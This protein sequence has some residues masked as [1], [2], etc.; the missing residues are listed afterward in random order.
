M[1]VDAGLD[2]WVWTFS[3]RSDAADVEA[4]K[5]ASIAR[6]R[7]QQR[8]AQKKYRAN[9]KESIRALAESWQEKNRARVL[10]NSARS[11]ASRKNIEFSIN[12]GWIEARLSTGFCEATGIAFDFRKL[13]RGWRNPRAP[14]IDRKDSARGYTPDN[15]Q[16]VVWQYNVAKSQYGL[17]DLVVL[18]TAIV[19][20]YG[21]VKLA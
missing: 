12:V 7:A 3:T 8:Q 4:Q 1:G 17:A 6:R 2:G 20:K 18:A 9:N 19:S 11:R 14:S 21:L 10:L 15:C 13:K 5:S 16:L